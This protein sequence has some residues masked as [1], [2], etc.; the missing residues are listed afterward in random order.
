MEASISAR[1]KRSHVGLA[2]SAVLSLFIAQHRRASRHGALYL[3]SQSKILLLRIVARLLSLLT[4]RNPVSRWLNFA[5]FPIKSTGIAHKGF[6]PFTRHRIVYLY[7]SQDRRLARYDIKWP[8]VQLA[9]MVIWPCAPANHRKIMGLL[10]RELM[11][12][13]FAQQI[14]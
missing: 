6:K 5:S 14:S 4:A 2:R 1:G 7:V 11:E 3:Q 12:A 10:I 13:K 8:G 9:M